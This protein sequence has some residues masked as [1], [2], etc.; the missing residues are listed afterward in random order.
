MPLKRYDNFTHYHWGGYC[1]TQC[2]Y[3][4][5]VHIVPV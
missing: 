3:D 4:I 5:V 2:T 1:V